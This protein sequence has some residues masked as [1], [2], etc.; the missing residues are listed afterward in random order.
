M[1]WFNVAAG[2]KPTVCTD[3]GQYF[4]LSPEAAY[5]PLGETL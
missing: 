5:A 4:K 3:C 2:D 1:R